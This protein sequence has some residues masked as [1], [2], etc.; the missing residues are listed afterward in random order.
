L[1]ILLGC[2][3]RCIRKKVHRRVTTELFDKNILYTFFRKALPRYEWILTSW[4]HCALTP[5]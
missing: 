2:N 4:Q 3:C 5:S 1:D